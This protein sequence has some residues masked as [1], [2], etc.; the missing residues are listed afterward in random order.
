MNMKGTGLVPFFAIFFFFSLALGLKLE[1]EVIAPITKAR[2]L[3]SAS[4]DP[5]GFVRKGQTFIVDGQS[6]EW[7]RISI[8]NSFVWI[9]K[10]AVKILRSEAFSCAGGNRRR[11]ITG[12]QTAGDNRIGT[13]RRTNDTGIPTIVKNRPDR[14]YRPEKYAPRNG[15]R[16]R[17]NTR[18]CNTDRCDCG[19]SA[20]HSHKK[21]ATKNGAGQFPGCCPSKG[22]P[23]ADTGGIAYMVFKKVTFSPG[24]P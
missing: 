5:K 2:T 24:P 3:P 22:L 23:A 14:H 4:S 1:V 13:T 21:Y 15:L 16:F 11:T 18:F 7:Y 9:P 8:Y 20:G 10:D 12:N 6:G 17:G 19:N